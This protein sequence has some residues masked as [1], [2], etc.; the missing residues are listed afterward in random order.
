MDWEYT[1]V[2]LNKAL[3]HAPLFSKG[4]VSTMTDGTPS[5]DTHGK[6][7]QLQICKLL[8]HKDMEVY[9]EGLSGEQEALKF[10]FKDL[11]LWDAAALAN[12]PMNHS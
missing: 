10:T 11:L 6:L 4:H 7:H 2:W 5:T 3:S 8:Q 12:P 9:L 1:F